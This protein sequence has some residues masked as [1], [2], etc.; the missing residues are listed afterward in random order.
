[1][2]TV[3]AMAVRPHGH[4]TMGVHGS[5]GQSPAMTVVGGKGIEN[6]PSFAWLMLFRGPGPDLG[7]NACHAIDG[8]L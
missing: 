1:M 2:N 4:P 3:Q 8:G 7:K 5:P 6:W